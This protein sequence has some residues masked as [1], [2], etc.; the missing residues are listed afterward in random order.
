V[1]YGGYT[2]GY[3]YGYTWTVPFEMVWPTR[4]RRAPQGYKVY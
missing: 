2:P 4:S 3:P 1:G